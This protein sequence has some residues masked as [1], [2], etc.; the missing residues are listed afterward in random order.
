[1]KIQY[2]GQKIG[3]P[4]KV[5]SSSNV[6]F[7]IPSLSQTTTILSIGLPMDLLSEVKTSVCRVF[8]SEPKSV[9]SRSL[10]V[11][12]ERGATTVLAHQNFHDVRICTLSWCTYSIQHRSTEGSFTIT[13]WMILYDHNSYSDHNSRRMFHI[14]TSGI[15]NQQETVV[16]YRPRSILRPKFNSDR[17]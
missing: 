6:Q 4:T 8:D 14:R 9:P 7:I 2:T 16:S 15:S 12:R 10:F 3:G 17:I 13:A 11:S 5:S 1:M